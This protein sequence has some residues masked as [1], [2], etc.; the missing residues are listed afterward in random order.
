MAGWPHS[1][2]GTQATMQQQ[3]NHN[4]CQRPGGKRQAVDGAADPETVAKKKKKLSLKT[5]SDTFLVQN[6]LA[7]GPK[8]AANTE[9]PTSRNASIK[10]WPSL[11]LKSFVS[12]A[13]TK[14]ELYP[15]V[16]CE[17]DSAKNN[18]QHLLP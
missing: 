8:E 3:N 1:T 4:N 11:L 7:V 14:I 16:K 9:K 17:S 12:N 15:F 2:G 5:I 13:D 18:A 6:T 10:R